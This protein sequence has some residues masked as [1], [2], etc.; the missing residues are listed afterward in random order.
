[1]TWRSSERLVVLSF[2]IKDK[3]S[4]WA[5]TALLKFLWVEAAIHEATASMPKWL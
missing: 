1:M 4:F 2:F 3:D 5:V